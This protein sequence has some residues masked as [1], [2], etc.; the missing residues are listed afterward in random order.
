MNNQIRL[1]LHL[2]FLSTGI[3]ILIAGL[4]M[5][6]TLEI[7]LY[8]TYFIFSQ[9][10]TATY[11]CCI[12]AVCALIYLILNKTGKNLNSNLSLVHYVATVFASVILLAVPF[13]KNLPDS[14]SGLET[15]SMTIMVT[16]LTFCMG[17]IV[18]LTNVIRSLIV[19]KR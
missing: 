5:K 3:I 11:I 2:L 18:F 7:Q 16:I 9:K 13:V 19:N 14:E 8:D 10:T 6:L 12:M 1:N 17:Q 4:L 15:L